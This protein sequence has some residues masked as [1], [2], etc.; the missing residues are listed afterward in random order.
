MAYPSLLS[1][2][3]LACL[4]LYRLSRTGLRSAELQVPNLE[5][6]RRVAR[7]SLYASILLSVSMAWLV[8]TD[9]YKSDYYSFFMAAGLMLAVSASISMVAMARISSH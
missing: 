5:L 2:I 4:A 6:W 1:L 7:V 8:Y 9:V 3:M